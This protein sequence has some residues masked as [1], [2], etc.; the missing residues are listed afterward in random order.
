MTFNQA[1]KET[2]LLTEEHWIKKNVYTVSQQTCL[3][4]LEKA[5]VEY[6]YLLRVDESKQ[7]GESYEKRCKDMNNELNTLFD[8]FCTDKK[9]LKKLE[10]EHGVPM[11][12]EDYEFYN[13]MRSDRTFS[14]GSIDTAYHKK[15]QEKK[16]K[17]DKKIKSQSTSFDSF[18][19]QDNEDIEDIADKD[20]VPDDKENEP[21]SKKKLIFQDISTPTGSI[22]T[23]SS[24]T[25]QYE[26][27]GINSNQQDDKRDTVHVRTSKNAVMSEIY[28]AC[29]E[30]E[31]HG[32][33][34]SQMQIAL[35]VVGNFIFETTWKIPEEK[36]R[37]SKYDDKD[38]KLD[39]SVIDSDTLPT[40][41]A[42]R[43]KLK[44]MHAYSLG[45]VADKVNSAADEGDIITH[46]TDSTTRKHVGT[47]APS[48]LHINR[49]A[50]LP[51]PTLK[52]ASETTDNIAEGIKSTFE[53]LSCASS[54]SAA[55][56]YEKV[57][58]HMTDSTAHNKGV[59][60]QLAEKLER[61]E[62]AGQI[63]CTAHT[64]LGFDHRIEQVINQ[65]EVSMDMDN[66]FKGFLLDVNLNKNS[67]TLSLTFL[68]WVLNLFGPSFIQKPW[69]YHKDFVTF[70]KKKNKDV[71]LF[72][73]K[74]S[75]FASLSESAAVVCH[76]W[77]DFIEFLD[78]HDYIT[79]KLACLVRDA[80]K[81]EYILVVLAVIATFGVQLISP[82]FFKTISKANHSQLKSYFTDVYN[83]LMNRFIDESFFTFD[84]AC[85]DGVSDRAL[86][87]VIKEEYGSQV[88][89]SVKAR[90]IEHI[91]ECITLAN[92]LKGEMA[93]VLE[94]QRGKEYGFGSN[95]NSEYYV[96]DQAF[97]IDKAITNN[98]ELE[99]Q[100]GSHCNRL[101]KKPSIST[102]SR[103]NILKGTS[104]LRKNDKGNFE[105]FRKMGGVVKAI[106]RIEAKW[107][108][109]QEELHK[110]GLTSKE[111][112]ALHIANRRNTI[113]ESLKKEGGP[114]TNCIEVEE[115]LKSEQDPLIAQKRM[116]N[117]I[118]Y[119]RDT[120]TSLPRTCNLFKIMTV[121]SSTRKRRVMTANEFSVNLN[122]L[123]G[124][125]SERSTI[126]F[127]DFQAAIWHFQK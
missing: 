115:Y 113:L 74:D 7:S 23:R 101:Q 71:H 48:G 28:H 80:M 43:K 41:S 66:L 49:E 76:H 51:L 58:L 119:F 123:L 75:R 90:A 86:E 72:E 60:K 24:A 14:C 46:A 102:V 100:C 38:D 54:S 109:R 56:L 19:F 116:R 3:K 85:I 50:Y 67:E 81:F 117:E 45:L 94:N 65:I 17:L 124:K 104:E 106:E 64:T 11:T 118:T 15:E 114:F 107:N 40:R 112:Q 126:S 89:E 8:I 29:A 99:R 110:S 97:G 47:F 25:K 9:R 91:D 93:A 98:I 73:F 82:Y 18:S 53:M 13:N 105:K 52:I 5:L 79:N 26:S 121:D 39:D 62:P 6:R 125:S 12:N 34:L 95:P 84:G 78:Q 31:G 32:F 88:I 92:I 87:T 44:Q 20:F 96:F 77:D 69:N 103:G 37:M 27:D 30:M 83:S 42:I 120:C 63:F 4:R 2:A 33:S 70:L 127:S 22:S 61:E 111:Q 122:I 10:A 68:T 59:A 1:T 57:D 21:P 36:D 35:Q 16:R 108:K 55:E